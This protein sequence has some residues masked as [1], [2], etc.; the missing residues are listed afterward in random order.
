VPST[1][2]WLTV[3]E[4][5]GAEA[6]PLCSRANSTQLIAERFNVAHSYHLLDFTAGEKIQRVTQAPG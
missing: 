2:L 3:T 1:L 5:A 4:L 6:A